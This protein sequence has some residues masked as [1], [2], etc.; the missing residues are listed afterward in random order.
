MI[1]Y[2]CFLHLIAKHFLSTN[3]TININS[4][5]KGFAILEPA[6]ILKVNNRTENKLD[7][8]KIVYAWYFDI[9]LFY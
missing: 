5:G 9:L 7:M 6:L 2:Y 4:C 8:V 3:G 1:V